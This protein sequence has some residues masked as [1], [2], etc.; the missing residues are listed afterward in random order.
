ML[1]NSS[2]AFLM[3]IF[4]DSSVGS[5]RN[6]SDVF[7]KKWRQPLIKICTVVARYVVVDMQRVRKKL[8]AFP[9]NGISTVQSL[10]NTNNSNFATKHC[11][12]EGVS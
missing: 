5:F 6:S 8:L 4:E 10:Q 2:L 12:F 11:S 9:A 1:L 7:V 3:L